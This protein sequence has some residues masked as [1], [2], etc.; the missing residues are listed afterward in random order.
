MYQ[1]VRD[2]LSKERNKQ[3]DLELIK[4]YDFA[5]N[6]VVAL[7]QIQ[8][9]R[10]VLLNQLRDLGYGLGE[11]KHEHII[12]VPDWAKLNEYVL[13]LHE[14]DAAIDKPA[15]L[16]EKIIGYGYDGVFTQAHNCPVYFYKFSDYGKRIKKN[17]ES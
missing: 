15:W 11:K 17:N 16:S 7:P 9:E 13:V 3:T 14:Y 4:A 2:I 12:D 6:S 8:W 5:I 10:D 1:N